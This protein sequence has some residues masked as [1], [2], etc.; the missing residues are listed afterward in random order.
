MAAMRF[1]LCSEQRVRSR[2]GS[3][4]A[5]AAAPSSLR[6]DAMAM[7]D[8]DMGKQAKLG[9]ERVES[10]GLVRDC[11]GDALDDKALRDGDGRNAL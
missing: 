4:L 7:A 2:M 6:R 8:I 5:T 9:A 3:Y 10:D 11:S 1:K